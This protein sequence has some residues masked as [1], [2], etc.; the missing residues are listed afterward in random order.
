M[1]TVAIPPKSPAGL[2]RRFGVI[3]PDSQPRPI[4]DSHLTFITDAIR[5]KSDQPVPRSMKIQFP[6]FKVHNTF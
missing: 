1:P 6:S 4:V 3:Y 5:K 2:A